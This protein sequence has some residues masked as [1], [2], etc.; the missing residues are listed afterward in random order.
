M[1]NDIQ[2]TLMFSIYL[3]VHRT[4]SREYKL[5]ETLYNQ[6]ITKSQKWSQIQKSEE[7]RH[8]ERRRTKTKKII[9][10]LFRSWL[11]Q[12]LYISL[13]LHLSRPT[14]ALIVSSATWI[15]K[16]IRQTPQH[17]IRQDIGKNLRNSN[18]NEINQFRTE[19]S[20]TQVNRR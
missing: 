6:E 17:Q 7:R 14:H 8:Q 13:K 12:H 3:C 4:P 9:E 11:V 2:E 5:Y 1:H 10:K 19:D 18:T 16:K 20:T 15:P